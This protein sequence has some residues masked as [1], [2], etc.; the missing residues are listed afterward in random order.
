MA[1]ANEG[2]DESIVHSGLVFVSQHGQYPAL[3]ARAAAQ[4]P[5]AVGHG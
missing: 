3:D 4:R 1:Q 2:R 5:V